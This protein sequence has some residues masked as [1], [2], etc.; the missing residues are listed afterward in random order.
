[1][2]PSYRKLKGAHPPPSCPH[3]GPQALR[4]PAL[5]DKTILQMWVNPEMET[6]PWTLWAQW[7]N[8]KGP[9]KGENRAQEE[10][11]SGAGSRD[12]G[13][14]SEGGGT[15]VMLW[16]QEAPGAWTVKGVKTSLHA[17]RRS[18]CQPLG[19]RP[20]ELIQTSNP[21]NHE[22]MNLYWF[23]PLS[24]WH[25]TAEKETNKPGV[26]ILLFCKHTN[27]LKIRRTFLTSSDLYYLGFLN[28]TGI[29]DK[30]ENNPSMS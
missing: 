19:F 15:A 1:M 6:E 2:L 26:N 25:S 27:A 29:Q 7:S 11:V 10:K 4:C 24:L 18:P 23:K 17:S 3:L 5:Y 21:Q 13:T 28:N 30:N 16:M 9:W 14:H 8:H 22:I 20:V 12:G